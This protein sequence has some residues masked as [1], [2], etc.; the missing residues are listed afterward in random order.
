MRSRHDLGLVPAHALQRR[1]VADEVVVEQ[2]SPLLP[3]VEVEHG[4]HKAYPVEVAISGRVTLEPTPDKPVP[5]PQGN[6]MLWFATDIGLVRAY[7]R[8][9][10]GWEL[11]SHT[12]V[13]G[14][15]IPF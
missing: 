7:N 1:V 8:L 2:L 5:M 14:E 9:G 4:I 13:A 10:E 3:D 12:N 11:S 6:A 15:E